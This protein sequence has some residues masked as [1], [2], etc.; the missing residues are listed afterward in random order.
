M[1]FIHQL[2]ITT[3]KIELIFFGG[4]VLVVGGHFTNESQSKLEDLH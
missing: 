3:C 4:G 2:D 1:V